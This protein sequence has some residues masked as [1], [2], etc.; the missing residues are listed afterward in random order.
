MI[1]FDNSMQKNNW[2]KISVITPTLNSARTIDEYFKSIMSQKYKGK[3][4]ILII[5][6]GSSDKTL[7]VAK[8]NGARVIFNKLKTAEAGKALGVKNSTGSIYAFIDSDNILVGD[9][10]LSKMVGP[11]VED[12]SIVAS[13]PITY[14]YRKTDH[15]LTRY[16]ALIGMGDPVNLFIGNYDRYSYISNK[17][18][19]LKLDQENRKGYI[20]I[21]LENRIPTIGANG[22]LI[23]KESF[24]N[25][26]L[27]DYLFDV[28]LIE[29]LTKNSSIFVSK[30]DV[31][32]VHL[33]SGDINTFVRKQRRRIRDYLYHYYYKNSK[34]TNNSLESPFIFWGIAKFIV[35]CLLLLPLMYQ[36]LVG[37]NRKRDIAWFFHPFACLITLFAY[38][39]ETIR[40]L[41]IHEEYTRIGW[42]Q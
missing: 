35:S 29:T 40:S 36:M 33:F 28:D 3:I 30:V 17:W 16:F 13:E 18:T 27:R 6:G 34:K 7:K 21:K 15:W 32:I 14:S 12:E 31:G 9:S 23:K 26:K 2:P 10:W 24:S 8:E 39:Y 4:E 42:K 38:T 41:F 25:Y 1:S 20:K 11:F 37:F 22:F 5:D 19:G